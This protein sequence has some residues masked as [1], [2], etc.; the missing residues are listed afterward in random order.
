MSKIRKRGAVTVTALCL[1]GTLVACSTHSVQASSVGDRII[2][3]AGQASDAKDAA[4]AEGTVVWGADGCMVI[5][6]DMAA[7]LVVFPHGTTIAEDRKV[8]FPS[9]YGIS[10]GDQ[11]AL[12]GGFHP[13]DTTD[14]KNIPEGCLT[15]EVFWASGEVSE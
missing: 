9:G 2:A 8:T 1:L 7:F 13:A 10:A 14:L 12:G 11:V 3:V 5:E 6:A 4:L 15:D